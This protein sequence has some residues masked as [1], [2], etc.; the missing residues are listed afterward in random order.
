MS[1]TAEQKSKAATREVAHRL[2]VYRRLVA[3]GVMTEEKANYEIDIMREIA[4]DYYQLEAEE[5]LL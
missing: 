2:T 1:F 5:R 4:R 3:K